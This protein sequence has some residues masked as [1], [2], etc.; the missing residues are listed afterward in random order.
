MSVQL[1]HI[2]NPSAVPGIPGRVV[3]RQFALRLGI[4]VQEPLLRERSGGANDRGGGWLVE[5]L[6]DQ[7]ALHYR[8]AD[9]V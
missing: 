6:L 3:R 1:L 9:Q 5:R 2:F 4:Q 7:F 8:G